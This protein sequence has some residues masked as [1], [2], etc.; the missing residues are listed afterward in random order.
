MAGDEVE[1]IVPKQPGIDKPIVETFPLNDDL[2]I[3]LSIAS[4]G[5]LRGKHVVHIS[6]EDMLG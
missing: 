1:I 3:K 6:G 5:L 2:C 4:G